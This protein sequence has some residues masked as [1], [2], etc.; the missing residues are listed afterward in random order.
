M[1]L[2]IDT[3]FDLNVQLGRI[4][5]GVEKGNANA[6]KLRE[7][8]RARIPF[9]VRLMASGV[10]PSPTAP[11]GLNFGGP[12]PGF[13]WVVRRIVV[14]GLLWSTTA[15]G[16]AEVYVHGF[17]GAQGSITSGS[18]TVAGVRALSDLVDE[19]ATLPSKGFYSNEQV[20]V[21]PTESLSVVVVTGTAG[22]QY[23]ANCGIQVV[24]LT[25]SLDAEIEV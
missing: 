10:C 6:R 18:G 21:Q 11:F 5:Q 9:P 13:F 20:I 24:R 4:A 15:A 3:G 25:S 22:Q 19:A 12:D 7:I 1:T 8:A 16:S 14:G 2:D 23:V 17:G